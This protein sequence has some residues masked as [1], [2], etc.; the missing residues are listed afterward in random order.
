MARTRVIAGGALAALLLCLPAAAAP[1][2]TVPI[3]V[4]LGDQSPSI[5]DQRRFQDLDIKRVR[6]F[7]KWNAIGDDYLLQQADQFVDAATRHGATVFM[8]PSSDNLE[9]GQARLPSVGAYRRKV[10]ALVKRYRRMG[11]REWGVWNEANHDSQPTYRA[12]RRAAR[13]FKTMHGLC[14]GCTIVALDV[15]EQVGVE[16]YVHRFFDALPRRWDRRVRIV[17][18]HNYADVNRKQTAG[19]QEIFRTVRGPGGNRHARF[20]ITETGGLVAF[21]DGFP[22]DPRRAADRIRYMFASV[23]KQTAYV[24]R[25]YAYAY[26]GNDCSE[27]FDAGLVNADGSARP[28]YHAFK[29]AAAGFLR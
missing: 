11:V 7:I 25:L 1:A 3:R 24:D 2:A 6:Y 28:G 12:P 17:G 9:P 26:W 16:D 27:R 21:G 19:T 14:R 4:G 29:R 18:I 15:L 22:C 13:F 20:W 8:T 5:F 10:G 23:R